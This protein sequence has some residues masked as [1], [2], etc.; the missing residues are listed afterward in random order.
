MKNDFEIGFEMECVLD[1]RVY[2]KIQLQPELDKICRGIKI[3]DDAS[4]EEYDIPDDEAA[5]KG[6]VYTA[7]LV[8]PPKPTEEAMI[9]LKK[10]FALIDKGGWTNESTGLHIN[11]SPID[12]KLFK[13][14]NYLYIAFHPLFEE[15]AGAYNRDSNI[16]SMPNDL[17]SLPVNLWEN[18]V[19]ECTDG[20]SI[21][22]EKE[23]AVNLDYVGSNYGRTRRIEVRAF[24]NKDYQK[25]LVLTRNYTYKILEVL[26]NSVKYNFDYMK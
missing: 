21:Y 14:M 6:Y 8:T 22:H 17:T 18:L 9:V 7:E 24:G 2:N 12:K 4:I 10:M 23:A 16:Y 1:Q 3:D 19:S 13:K 26:R 25:K 11:I 20:I 15:I 5:D